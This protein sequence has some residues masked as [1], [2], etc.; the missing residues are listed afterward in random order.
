MAKTFDITNHLLVPKHTK[1]SDKEKKDLL[2]K[3]KINLK[4][5]P[6]IK[7]NDVAIAKLGAKE[8]DVIK[9]VRN[10]PTAGEAIFYR[11][12]VNV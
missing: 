11:G 4:E 9:I 6:K 5:L 2:A 1:I 7:K 10:S 3:Y 8:G 12:V